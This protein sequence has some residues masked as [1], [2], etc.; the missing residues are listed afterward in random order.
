MKLTKLLPFALLSSVLVLSGCA[1]TRDDSVESALTLSNQ[2]NYQAAA[3]TFINEKGEPD[4][5]DE[6]LETLLLVGK[7]FHD[8]GMWQHS[9]D[10]FEKA[11]VELSWKADEVDTGEEF[12][13]LVGTTLSSDVFGDY[14]GRIYEGVLI[15]YYQTLNQLMLADEDKVRVHL[16]RSDLRQ[17]N[18]EIQFAN[19]VE[20]VAESKLDDSGK[21]NQDQYN[22]VRNNIEGDVNL[23]ISQ[24]PRASKVEIRN[25]MADLLGAFLRVSGSSGVDRASSKVDSALKNAQ[26]V[27][28][29]Q[30]GSDQIFTPFQAGF[31]Q[32]D[33]PQVLVIFEDGVGP[34]VDE[35]RLD[36]PLFLL[37][38][39]VLYS[40]IALPKFEPGKPAKQGLQVRAGS[41]IGVLHNVTDINR[42]A[43][44]EFEASYNK[45]V[46]KQ[47]ASA[48]IKTAAQILVNNELEKKA[49]PYVSLLG[50]VVT[51]GAQAATTRAD[52]RHWSNLPNSIQ[53][54]M[55]MNDGSGVLEF[56]QGGVGVAQIEIP[57]DQDV[58]VY[59]RS[60]ASN[61][62]ITAYVRSLPLTAAADVQFAAN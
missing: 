51:A 11:A 16:N 31:E 48:V 50:K 6:D 30:H 35:F 7:V 52:T 62:A 53:S 19:Y 27:M 38:D 22:T 58:I 56:I 41:Q 61:G 42:M 39:D 36:L 54:T 43:S 37:T 33:A 57:T 59:A 15:D 12:V 13:R 60:S 10:A 21:L 5:D 25:S 47:I 45:K 24:L 18:A 55:L 32:I 49:N 14:T 26:L 9:Y 46:A 29:S 34:K 20:T 40:G 4:Y 44:L 23:G 17:E 2:G 28:H 1:S 3:A 8:A